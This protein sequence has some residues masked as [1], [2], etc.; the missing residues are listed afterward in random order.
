[1][2]NKLEGSSVEVPVGVDYIPG[3]KEALENRR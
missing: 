3:L 1:L 2:G